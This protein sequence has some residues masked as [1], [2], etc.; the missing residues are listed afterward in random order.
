M[1]F[2]VVET[3]VTFFFSLPQVGGNSLTSDYQQPFM[4]SVPQICSQLTQCRQQ[5][6]ELHNKLLDSKATVQAQAAQ[7]EQY[8][9]LLIEYHPISG[10]DHI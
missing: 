8:R 7:L 2:S 6:Q 3:T 4:E 5:C 1:P 9:A 10:V